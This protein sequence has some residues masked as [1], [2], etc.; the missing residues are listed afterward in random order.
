MMKELKSK[1]CK[2]NDLYYIS[3]EFTVESFDNISFFDTLVIGPVLYLSTVKDLRGG[4]LGRE[5]LW[6][7]KRILLVLVLKRL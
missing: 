6:E 2:N 7:K 4:T 3:I 5:V 1:V